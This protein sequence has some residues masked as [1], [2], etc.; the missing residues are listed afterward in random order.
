MGWPKCYRGRS[1]QKRDRPSATPVLA[2]FRPPPHQ[3]QSSLSPHKSPSGKPCFRRD[4]SSL[5]LRF[6]EIGVRNPCLPANFAR[7][8]LELARRDASSRRYRLRLST[9][10]GVAAVNIRLATAKKNP[11]DHPHI[12]MP[13]NAS[14]APTNCH[15]FG[16]T[17]SP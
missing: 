16:S 4:Q 3:G 12:R 9:A 8:Y 5:L 14:T 10:Q 7:S 11:V 15:S 6:C 2:S 17:R 13:V 1:R